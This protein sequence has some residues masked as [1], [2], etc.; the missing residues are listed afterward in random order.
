MAVDVQRFMDE[1]YKYVRIQQG[2]YGGAGISGTET[3]INMANGSNFYWLRLADVYLLYAE[4][5]M[6]NGDN[7]TALEYINKVKRRAYGYPIDAPSPVDYTSLTDKTMAS[8]P[9]LMNDPLKYERWAELFGEG[10]WWFDVR[11]W[12]IGAQEADYYERV[13]GGTIQWE[14]T[15][16]AQPIPILEINANVQMEQNPGY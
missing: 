8:D 11:R 3:E 12:Q 16:Y 15:D 9:V 14:S 7:S 4:T 6:N 2:G 10:H 5:L 1:G 13:R